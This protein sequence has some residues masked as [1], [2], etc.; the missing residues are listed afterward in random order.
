MISP[1]LKVLVVEDD[2][3]L[4]DLLVKNLYKANF[5]VALFFDAEDA[6]KEL[7]KGVFPDVI[8]LD[9]ILPGMNGFEFLE[10]I[11]KEEETKSIPVIILSNLGSEQDIKKG[12]D[13]G[14]S[15]YLVKAHI[16]P[17]DLVKK[18]KEVVKNAKPSA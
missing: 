14:A 1:P 8:V 17:D 12:L 13:L 5:E 10:K 18:I 16:L 4:A 6:Y 15:L 3:F 2:Q 11:K 9:L 7:K